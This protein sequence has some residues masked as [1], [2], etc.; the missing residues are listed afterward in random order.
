MGFN[1]LVFEEKFENDGP[2]NPAVWN[3]EVGPKWANNELQRYTD[4]VENCFVKNGILNLVAKIEAPGKYVSARINTQGNKS[5][6]YGRFIVKAK[7]PKGV[8][9]WPAIWFLP[10]DIKLGVRWPLC[11]EI[12]LMEHTGR[13]PEVVF[14][15]L[16][17][18]TYNHRIGTEKSVRSRINGSTDGFHDYEMIWTKESI[19]FKVDGVEQATFIKGDRDTAD[20]W[21]FDKSFFLILNIAV[22]GTFGGPVNEDD[23]PYVMQIRSIRVFQ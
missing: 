19:I 5:W 23:L 3:H 8:G 4:A 9:S 22:G 6:T 11:G 7:L 1:K 14:Y 17:S 16:H 12:D 2:V 18:K 15:S 10:E 20:E 13:D 21:P